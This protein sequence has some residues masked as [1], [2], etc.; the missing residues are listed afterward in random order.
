[1]FASAYASAKLCAEAIIAA[2]NGRADG[3]VARPSIKRR[4]PTFF[5]PMADQPRNQSRGPSL[6][7]SGG[8]MPTAASMSSPLNQPL[9]ADPYL[10]G[11]AAPGRRHS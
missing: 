8:S 1:V 6:S 10:T 11:A 9:A 2:G 4:F 5:G 3:R 7:I